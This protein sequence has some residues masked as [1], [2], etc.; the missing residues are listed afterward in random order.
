MIG[1]STERQAEKAGA[2]PTLPLRAS[3]KPDAPA[4]DVG[5]GSG[6]DAA[7]LCDLGYEV[8]TVEPARG[9]RGETLD[10]PHDPNSDAGCAYEKS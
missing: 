4:L 6:R 10:N 1:S 3:P 5:A 9:M 7:W 2:W 8:V